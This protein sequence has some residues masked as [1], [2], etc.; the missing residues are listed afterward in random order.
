MII[1]NA[2]YTI[3]I[4]EEIPTAVQWTME[5]NERLFIQNRIQY[6]VVRADRD[7]VFHTAGLQ[8]EYLKIELL[9]NYQNVI[10]CDWDVLFLSVPRFSESRNCYFGYWENTK[11]PDMF[12]T[13]HDGIFFANY[14]GNVLRGINDRLQSPGFTS[15]VAYKMLEHGIAKLYDGPYS[16]LNTNCGL[17][18][19]DTFREYT[20]DKKEA[21]NRR[22]LNKVSALGFDMKELEKWQEP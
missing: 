13:W 17:D 19:Y 5:R 21:I 16:H 1:P 11:T 20:I 4:G 12:L 9:S 10:V 8:A 6:E 2:V 3:I 18:S 14:F 15:G 7:K 22:F